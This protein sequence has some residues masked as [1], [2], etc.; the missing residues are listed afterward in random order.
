MTNL[1]T[2]IDPINE[3]TIEQINLRLTAIN[4]LMLN[5]LTF[6]KIDSYIG[7][8][9]KVRRYTDV[10]FKP[11]VVLIFSYIVELN[12]YHLISIITDSNKL[13]P[14]GFILNNIDFIVSNNEKSVTYNYIIFK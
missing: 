4:N 12:E 11:K 8:G 2:R 9:E 6:T 7:N 1:P 10:G 5:F 14:D 3:L 13:L